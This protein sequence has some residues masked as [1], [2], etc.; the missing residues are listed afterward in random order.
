MKSMKSQIAGCLIVAAAVVGCAP[1]GGG[2]TGTTTTTNPSEMVTETWLESAD[3]PSGER[4]M[5]RH[6]CEQ[7]GGTYVQ[8]PFDPSHGSCWVEARNK[9]YTW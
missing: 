6:F 1:T 9:T 2:P 5:T 3:N 8:N 7:M 4:E